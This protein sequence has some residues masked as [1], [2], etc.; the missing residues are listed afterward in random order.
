M[1]FE[2]VEILVDLENVN[3]V[4]LGV[5]GQQR[6]GFEAEGH[7]VDAWLDFQHLAHE[8]LFRCAALLFGDYEVFRGHPAAEEETVSLILNIL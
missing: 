3:D 4:D 5:G 7:A 1:F 2:L 8:E 6:L